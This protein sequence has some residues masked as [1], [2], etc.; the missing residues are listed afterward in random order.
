MI[1][2]N[3][4]KEQKLLDERGISLSDISEII[5]SGNVLDEVFVPNHKDHPG[6]KMFVVEYDGDIACVPFVKDDAG[7]FFLKTAFF[8]RVARKKFGGENDD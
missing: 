8:S 4:D 5:E 3:K 7:N 6:Q 1:K 2:W